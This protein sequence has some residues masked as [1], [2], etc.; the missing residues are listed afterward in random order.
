[1]N[2]ILSISIAYLLGAIPSAVWVSKLYKGIDIREFGSKNAGLTNVFRVLGYKPALPVVFVDLGKGLAAPYIAAQLCPTQS[3]VP[4]TAGIAAI[5]GHSF[6]CFAGFKGGK[7]V[8]TALGVFLFLAPIPALLSFAVWVAV[9]FSTRYV[10]LG[11]ILACS[12]LGL[13]LSWARFMLLPD[14]ALYAST[15]LWLAGMLVAIFVI[16]KH[17]SNIKRLLA[18]TEN[19]FGV[20]KEEPIK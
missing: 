6:T 9:T 2:S 20:K 17:K 8:L 16:L 12:M 10:S 14:H 7:G 15:G 1:L 4:L 11:S 18:G 19:R 5:F 13:S 3:W